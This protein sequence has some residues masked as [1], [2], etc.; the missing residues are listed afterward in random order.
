MSRVL[1]LLA[2]AAT[3]IAVLLTAG[4]ALAADPEPTALPAAPG[5]EAEPNDSAATATPIDAG[6]RIRAEVS[7]GD[8]DNYS[9]TAEAGDRVFATVMTSGS[10]SQSG[11]S[12][13]TLLGTDGTTVI[14][15]DNDDG[16]LGG[17]SSSIAGAAIPAPGTY[18]LAVRHDVAAGVL[19]PYDLLLDVRSGAPASEAEPNNGPFN[20]TPLGAGF[21]A[22]ARN[23]AGD[24]D[25][26]AI[27]LSVGDTVFLSLDLDPERDGT[28]FNGRLG[29]GAASR[30]PGVDDAG[31]GDP[32][33]EAYV[34][35]VATAGTY[36][37]FV[38]SAQAA[39]GGPAATYHLSVTVIPA[40]ERSCR[41]YAIAPSPGTIPDLGTASFPI[42]VP[43]AAT[44]DH[45]AIA[46]DIT[47]PFMNDLTAMLQ[48]PAGNEIVLFTQIGGATNGGPD[49]RM[50][51]LF[52]DNAGA[53]PHNTI[54]RSFALQPEITARLSYFA[55][56]QAAGRWNLAFRDDGLN[57][58]GTLAR[59]QLIICA[60][61]EEGPVESV[62]SAGF[63]SGDDGF[64]HSGTADEWERGTPA[65]PTTCAEGERCFKT[66]LDGTYEP[67]S[68]QDLV[69]P[70]ISLAGRTGTIYASWQMWYQL[71]GAD[72]DHATVSVEEDGGAN[73][74]RLFTW[75]G[76]DM[77]E[78]VA[79]PGVTVAMAAGWGAH[80]ADISAYAGK[81]IRLRF[82]LDSNTTFERAGLAIDDVRVYQ[83][84]FDLE[85]DIAGSGGGYVQSER[86]GLDCGSDAAAHGICSVQLG[87]SVTLTAHPDA[88]S[89]F[90]GFTGGGC[91][92]TETTCVV[93]LDEARSVTATFEVLPIAPVAEADA[94][95]TQENTPLS[96]ERPG[97]LNNDSDR[98][99]DP[100]TAAPA[101][102][103]E[104]GDLMLNSDG[105]FT[106]TPDADFNGRDSFMYRAGDGGLE[107]DPA[108][109]TIDVNAVDDPPASPPPA[110]AP[111]A[112]SDL[113]L[114]SRCVRRSASGRVRVP[115]TMRLAQVGPIVVRID[116][117]VGSRNRDGCPR[118]NRTRDYE[119]R[120][121][122]V[123]TVRPRTK[124]AA[125]AVLR[126]VT[127][128]LRL[129]PGLY[130]IGVQVRL[131]NGRLS[132]PVHAFLRVIG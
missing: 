45:V 118:Q 71:E 95:A 32:D 107:S 56:Q 58:V 73:P 14:E 114:G 33:S 50:L 48:A 120:F 6:E 41:T 53:P 9:F 86:G 20:A 63:E 94:Y 46:L 43:D 7:A 55:G 18:Y 25:T 65:T 23:P 13:L 31:A 104:H 34:A 70:P 97:V 51:T 68:S 100:L 64:T 72:F 19:R 8:V 60:R 105:S 132:P 92:G 101:S 52:D 93:S 108:T 49:T 90:A 130:R 12:H 59:A 16:S 110:A 54:L 2:A 112:I 85:V 39:S 131:E 74:R 38:D 42:D 102:E 99:D 83:P 26:Y 47:H 37:A 75:T 119:T 116:R 89:S 129:K 11:D 115:M 113:R 117:A 82:H 44:I 24:A 61:P 1:T 29:F 15:S 125:A 40:V 35:T 66:D 67:A 124:A 28:T 80:R 21:V 10:T 4:T 5:S 17:T 121:R 30:I 103:P 106:Y 77:I 69:S 109:V 76:A 91:S 96:V 126:R 87:G 62:F 98:N 27:G 88:E 122:R 81:T 36:Y 128:K 79:S 57:D 22:G 78:P 111:P 84:A 3:V 127:L 123:R